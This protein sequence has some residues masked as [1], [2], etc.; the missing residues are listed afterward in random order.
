VAGTRV[1]GGW[2]VYGVPKPEWGTKRICQACETRFYDL[3]HRPILCP[4]CN[5]EFVFEVPGKSRRLQEADPVVA[6]KPMVEKAPGSAGEEVAAVL[7][8]IPDV[9]ETAEAIGTGDRK[10]ENLIEDT[11]ELGEDEDDMAEVIENMEEPEE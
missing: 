5:A 3:N 9:V 11:S 1:Y 8:A 4:K 7:E 10:E 2:E 6:K